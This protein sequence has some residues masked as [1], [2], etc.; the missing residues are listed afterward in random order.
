[1]GKIPHLNVI[2]RSIHSIS[3]PQVES[4]GD[5]SLDS[6]CNVQGIEQSGITKR[7]EQTINRALFDNAFSHPFIAAPSDENDWD[8]QLTTL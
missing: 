8:L 1:M 4:A 7:L 2:A 3:P 6:Q 5:I